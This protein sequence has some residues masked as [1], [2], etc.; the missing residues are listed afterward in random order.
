MRKTAF[1]MKI[2]PARFLDFGAAEGGTVSCLPPR[3]R[4]GR[5]VKETRLGAA[6]GST[7]KVEKSLTPPKKVKTLKKFFPR[8]V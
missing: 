6:E 7:T 1:F 2:H 3:R 8:R 4:G 5:I